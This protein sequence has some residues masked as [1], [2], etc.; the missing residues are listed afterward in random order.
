MTGYGRCE[1]EEEGFRV[2][3]EMS[4]VNHRYCDLNIRMPRS[5][6]A[7]E[8]SVRKTI[9]EK[10]A[11]GKVEVSIYITQLEGEDVEILVNEKLCEAYLTAL[12]G[13]SKK[14]EMV[15]NIGTAEVMRWNDVINVQKKQAD[16]ESVWVVLEKCLQGA[17]SALLTMRQK[18][19]QALKADM[20]EKAAKIEETIKEI[21]VFGETVVEKY[22][23]RLLE[24]V[25]KLLDTVPIDENRLA[26]EIVLYADK[27][28]IDEELIRLASH[29]QQ[30]RAILEEQE[31]V[32]RKLDFLLQ[33]MNREANTIASKATD[34]GITNGAVALK[35]EIEKIREQIQ[36]IE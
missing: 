2:Q 17:I 14:Y 18:E 28:A 10:V 32:G 26:T 1:L 33:E 20:V 11:R 12:R 15:D 4:A 16:V 8:D 7:L 19:G 9:K 29:M 22:R 31:A 27:C 23:A 21:T 25:D 13:L 6:V 30:F 36:N 5:L 24:R 34:N 35:T 3:V